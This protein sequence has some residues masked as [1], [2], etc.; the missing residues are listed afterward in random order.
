MRAA[1]RGYTSAQS[2]C[3]SRELNDGFMRPKYPGQV[4]VSYYQAS[5]VAEYIEMK[6]GF[7]AIR[8][9]LGLYKAGKNTEQV[10]REA[11]NYQSRR[12]R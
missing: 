10:F 4:L 2:F 6:W 1:R 9:M 12:F 5:M 11:L 3:P 8:K 7:P